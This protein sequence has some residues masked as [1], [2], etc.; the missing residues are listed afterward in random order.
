MSKRLMWRI[1]IVEFPEIRCMSRL[2][3]L[4]VMPGKSRLTIPENL[5]LLAVQ[6]R[7]GIG[8]MQ[9]LKI[10]LLPIKTEE[11]G[12]ILPIV[13]MILFIL[14][15]IALTLSTTGSRNLFAVLHAKEAAQAYYASQAGLARALYAVKRSDAQLPV[16]GSFA[17]PTYLKN[18]ALPDGGI[19]NMTLTSNYN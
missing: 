6:V 1:L 2:F 9:N 17:T 10:D 12:I 15:I 13:I 14:L 16:C 5:W 3:Q 18:Q 11:K 4:K 19:F 8:C 7:M